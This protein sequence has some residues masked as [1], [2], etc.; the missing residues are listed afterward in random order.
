MPRLGS[1]SY[2]QVGVDS[3]IDYAAKVVNSLGTD[4]F[5]R[6]TLAAALGYKNPKSGTFST[7]MADLKLYGIIDGRGE[8]I[9]ATDLAQRLVT[10]MP[11]ELGHTIGEMMAQIPL[12]RELQERFRG[13][14]PTHEELLPVLINLTRADRLD[15]QKQV[16]AI[17][18]RFVEAA[19]RATF[20]PSQVPTGGPPAQAATSGAAEHEDAIEAAPPPANIKEFKQGPLLVR[21]P[22]EVDA[23]E[24]LQDLVAM[25]LKRAEKRAKRDQD[26]ADSTLHEASEDSA[27]SDVSE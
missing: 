12:F 10:P 21:V 26:K 24:E 27:P 11:G 18:D 22:D 5:D 20:S 14:T 4:N 1:Y 16:R 25:W 17:H 7:R 23:L 8:S 15:V 19:N 13:R 2:P 6:G 9:H 3:A